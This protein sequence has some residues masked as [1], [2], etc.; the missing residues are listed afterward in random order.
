MINDSKPYDPWSDERASGVV[1]TRLPEPASP[2]PSPRP[3]PLGSWSLPTSRTAGHRGY[4]VCAGRPQFW[5]PEGT[6]ENSPAFQRWVA[7]RKVASPEGTAEPQS[8]TPSFSRPFGTCVPQAMFPGVKT[9]GYSQDVPPGQRSLVAAF[10]AKKATRLR[11]DVF[12]A[13]SRPQFLARKM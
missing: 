5:C 13:I 7:R 3:S 12:K 8:R 9:P 1:H 2:F 10:S 11:S 4:F 6:I